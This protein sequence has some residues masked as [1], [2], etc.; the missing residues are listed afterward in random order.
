MALAEEMAVMYQTSSI[1]SMKERVQPPSLLSNKLN[2]TV[3][4]TLLSIAEKLTME[5]LP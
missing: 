5:I 2:S 1:A 4:R 3:S